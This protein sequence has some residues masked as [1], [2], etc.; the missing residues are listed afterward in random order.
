LAT[1]RAGSRP[2]DQEFALTKLKRLRRLKRLD[3]GSVLRA[4]PAETMPIDR[5]I[6]A[7]INVFSEG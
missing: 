1:S 5:Y 6:K 2:V 3:R 7:Q 4:R